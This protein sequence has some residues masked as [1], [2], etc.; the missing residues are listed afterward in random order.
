MDKYSVL[1][2]LYLKEKPEYLDQAI[3]SMVN[4]TLKPDEIVIVKDGLITNELQNVL[5]KYSYKYPDL[6]HIVGYE[7]N[8]GL[9]Y[10]LNY[11]LKYCKNELVA[12]MDTDDI[13]VIDRCEKQ[14][15]FMNQNPSI[16]IVGGEIEEFMV[17][18]ENCVGKRLVPCSDSEIKEYM[19]KRCPFNHMTVMFKKTEIIEA[20]SYKDWHYNEDY[21]LWIRLALLNNKFANLSDILVNVRVGTDMYKRRGGYEYF[22]SEKKIQKLMLDYKIINRYRYCVN[23]IERLMIQVFMP[24]TIRKFVFKKFARKQ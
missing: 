22:I 8:R 3:E 23:V 18:T 20:G 6:F 19:K 9:G 24:N 10:A 16:A 17:D 1:M 11:G 15:A 12:R 5:E 13:A 4:Q 14:V 2:S 21:Y 7:D